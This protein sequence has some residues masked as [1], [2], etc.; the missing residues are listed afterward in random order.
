MDVVAI[1]V[2]DATGFRLASYDGTTL[3]FP[4]AVDLTATVITEI[5]AITATGD[6]L[7]VTGNP[8]LFAVMDITTKPSDNKLQGICE[9]MWHSINSGNV[10]AISQVLLGLS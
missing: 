5:P 3:V 7:G 6:F 10:K 9:W 1:T 2:N 8:G 4:T